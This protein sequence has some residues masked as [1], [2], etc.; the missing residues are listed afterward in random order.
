[1]RS[2]SATAS[3]GRR[4]IEFV[5]HDVT[6]VPFPVADADVVF[7]RYLL[8]HLPDPEALV[9]RWVG[10]IRVGGRL[11]VEEIVSIDTDHPVL[12]R[13]VELVIALSAANG[14]DLLVGPPPR[15]DRVGRVGRPRRHRDDRATAATSWPGS[16]P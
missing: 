5:E 16:S 7:A 14:T 8:A 9:A 3:P 12:G 6:I 4:T 2:A 13:Y 10:Q 15:S 1:M 11:L